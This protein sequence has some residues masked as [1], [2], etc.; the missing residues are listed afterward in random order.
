M[1]LSFGFVI[2]KVHYNL[3][4]LMSEKSLCYVLTYLCV[5]SMLLTSAEQQFM[6]QI[7]KVNIKSVVTNHWD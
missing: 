1:F 2:D 4:F 5:V 3:V 7:G 6:G